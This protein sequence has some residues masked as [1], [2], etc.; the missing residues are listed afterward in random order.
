VLVGV[1][2]AGPRGMRSLLRQR[3]DLR[4]EVRTLS[5]VLGLGLAWLLVWGGVARADGLETV[6]GTGT[7]I[8]C[9]QPM[10]HV[11]AQSQQGGVS[12]Q[13]HFWIRYPSGVEFGGRVVCLSALAN[14]AGLTGKIEIVKV[15]NPMLGFVAGHYLTIRITDNGSPG[16]ADLVNFDPG[17]PVPP[18][19]CD[20]LGDLK[21][22]QGNYVVHD[23][24]NPLLDLSAFDA[25]LTGFEG[26][27]GDPYGMTG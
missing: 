6:A 27:A 12:P 16:T 18:V 23:D 26:A 21:T 25:L 9:G 13:G 11:N 2:R 14:S 17:T 1:R 10:V 22:Q 20:A 8:C 3:S 5:L 24:Y 15:A 19:G 7:L 4:C